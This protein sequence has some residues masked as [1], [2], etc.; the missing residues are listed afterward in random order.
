MKPLFSAEG[1]K[2]CESFAEPKTGRKKIHIFIG[3]KKLSKIKLFAKRD[4]GQVV[5]F[6]TIVKKTFS[7]GERVFNT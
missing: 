5:F 4:R 7:K 1:K 3:Q 6:P 2:S